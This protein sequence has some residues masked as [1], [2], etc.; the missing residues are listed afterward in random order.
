[1]NW[2][3]KHPWPMLA[4]MEKCFLVCFSVDPEV[5]KSQLPDG[6]EPHL[7]QGK[8]LVCIA[9]SKLEDMRPDFF[10]KMLGVNYT[11]VVY[12]AVVNMDG[13]TG[14][15]FLNS[16]TDN[17]YMYLAGKLLSNFK[18]NKSKIDFNGS[19]ISIDFYR[20]SLFS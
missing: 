6:I 2:L 7:Y 4:K 8:A 19:W 1:M 15:Y 10:P 14:V 17:W 9:I 11:Q 12:R 5:V 3:P 13:K 16:T 18:L 20:F